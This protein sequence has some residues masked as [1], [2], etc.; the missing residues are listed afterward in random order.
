MRLARVGSMNTES[1]YRAQSARIMRLA[2]VG[3]MYTESTYGA[4]SLK[5]TSLLI[6]VYL[7][8]SSIS[9]TN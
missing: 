8:I 5:T 6:N 4:Q 9:Q 2:K 7:R 1:A 3:S